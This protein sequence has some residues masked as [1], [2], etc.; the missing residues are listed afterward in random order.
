MFASEDLGLEEVV[1]FEVRAHVSKVNAEATARELGIDHGVV[2]DLEGVFGALATQH[3]STE[4]RCE[5][6]E[7]GLVLE[8]GVACAKLVPDEEPF[9][10]VLSL[11]DYSH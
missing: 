6:T 5:L 2:H 1:A 8:P 4:F 11:G 10:G 3:V 7:L 9:F